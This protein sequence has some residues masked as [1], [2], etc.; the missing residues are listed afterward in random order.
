MMAPVFVFKGPVTFSLHLSFP[1]AQ[2]D[3]LLRIGDLRRRPAL[4]Q[5]HDQG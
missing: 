4:R 1:S 3:V 2:Q 5:G